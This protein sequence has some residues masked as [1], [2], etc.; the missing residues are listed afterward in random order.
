MET[1][2]VFGILILFSPSIKD[3]DDFGVEGYLEWKCCDEI[4][5]NL[6]SVMLEKSHQNWIVVVVDA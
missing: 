4:F 5:L 6:G 2:S 3:L 1:D